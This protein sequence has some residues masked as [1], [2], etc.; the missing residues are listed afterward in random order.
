MAEP[1][2]SIRAFYDEVQST[3]LEELSD[4]P[5]YADPLPLVH[6]PQHRL[7]VSDSKASAKLQD[8]YPRIQLLFFDFS[9]RCS[10]F[11]CPQPA[12]HLHSIQARGVTQIE[13][14]PGVLLY[15]QVFLPV[16]PELLDAVL[17]NDQKQENGT[18][19]VERLVQGTFAHQFEGGADHQ[20]G[21][22]AM[23]ISTAENSNK[24]RQPH[25]GRHGLVYLSLG[26]DVLL[27]LGSE[28]MLGDEITAES[29]SGGDVINDDDWQDLVNFDSDEESMS[30]VTKDRAT[31]VSKTAT[32][33]KDASTRHSHLAA[34]HLRAGDAIVLNERASNIW[35]GIAKVLDGSSVPEPYQWPHLREDEQSEGRITMTRGQ[36]G[37]KAVQLEFR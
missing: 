26:S 16:M 4:S 11:N 19:D 7:L 21:S 5:K 18:S 10:M 32:S 22:L 1:P 31:V 12:R 23:S 25:L 15:P 33:T 6:L 36:L 13:G 27:V 29:A 35:Y 8:D 30:K 9:G 2:D 37:G 3:S 24:L 20:D 34:V 17:G 28:A 14:F